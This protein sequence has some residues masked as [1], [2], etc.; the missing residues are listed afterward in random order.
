VTGR[1]PA[2]LLAPLAL[3]VTAVALFA[4]VSSGGKT[5]EQSGG[6]ATPSATATPA[7]KAAK[8]KKAAAKTYTVKP[9]DTPS[10]IAESLGVSTAALLDANPNADPNALSPGQKLKLP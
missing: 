10:G 4:V 8:K 2:R 5:A 6:S 7:G 9:G 3:V 1:S